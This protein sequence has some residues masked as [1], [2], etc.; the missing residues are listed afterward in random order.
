MGA[1]SGAVSPG[2]P[3]HF[4]QRHPAP[5]LG[6]HRRTDKLSFKVNPLARMGFRGSRVGL[7]PLRGLAPL[8]RLC[9]S[10]ALR[11]GRVKIPPSRFQTNKGPATSSAA[12]PCRVIEEG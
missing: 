7:R 12:G 5:T 11:A 4:N 2:E 8:D 3:R 9:R 1:V 10:P 6:S